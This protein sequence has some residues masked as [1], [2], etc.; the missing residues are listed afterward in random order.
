MCVFADVSM[1]FPTA[2]FFSFCTLYPMLKVHL[3]MPYYSGG[4]LYE[5]IMERKRFTEGDA[6]S[7]LAQLLAALGA[8]HK[9]VCV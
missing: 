1:G 9:Y 6:A 2:V 4:E 7:V 8:L 3:I 5:R